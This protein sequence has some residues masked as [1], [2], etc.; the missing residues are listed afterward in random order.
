MRR[1]RNGGRQQAIVC[2]VRLIR[3]RRTY[4]CSIIINLSTL[5]VA[6]SFPSR[7]WRGFAASFLG[8]LD[9]LLV[10]YIL[11]APLV[12]VHSFLGVTAA[13]RCRVSATTSRVPKRVCS[14]RGIA[15]TV[16]TALDRGIYLEARKAPPGESAFVA[17]SHPGRSC[18]L[19]DPSCSTLWYTAPRTYCNTGFP[20]RIEQTQKRDPYW[21]EDWMSQ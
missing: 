21:N 1:V 13:I 4:T 17:Y 6:W 7:M 15:T 2:P 3:C 5:T 19:E 12:I 20:L 16:L 14:Y 11:R 9:A 8:I 18:A 10:P